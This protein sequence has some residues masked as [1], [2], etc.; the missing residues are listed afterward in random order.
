M[1]EDVLNFSMHYMREQR[2]FFKSWLYHGCKR[3]T[4]FVLCFLFQKAKHV[5]ITEHDYCF[6]SV[7]GFAITLTGIPVYYIFVKWKNKSE[8]CERMFSKYKVIINF[9]FSCGTFH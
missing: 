3:V 2:I 8:G 5:W 1:V 6:V 9:D 7:I 4:T